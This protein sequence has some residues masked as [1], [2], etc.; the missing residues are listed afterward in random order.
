MRK[1]L[2]IIFLILILL[3]ITILADKVEADNETHSQKSEIVVLVQVAPKNV[4][5]YKELHLVDLTVRNQ[6]LQFNKSLARLL[7]SS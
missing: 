2:M 1:V 5:P 3:P 7:I 6:I 4:V